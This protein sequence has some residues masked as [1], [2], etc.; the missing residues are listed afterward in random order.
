MEKV[1]SFKIRNIEDVNELFQYHRTLVSVFNEL[2]ESGSFEIIPIKKGTFK[3]VVLD[4][5][6]AEKRKVKKS[7]AK[8]KV[9][10]TPKLRKRRVL[11]NRKLR[12]FEVKGKVIH[13]IDN[14][15]GKTKQVYH[16]HTEAQEK[17]LINR[18]V[19]NDLRFREAGQ[20]I[21]NTKKPQDVPKII[22]IETKNKHI[23]NP[24]SSKT[25]LSILYYDGEITHL[26]VNT[27]ERAIEI[28][29]QRNNFIQGTQQRT[30][31]AATWDNMSIL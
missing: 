19:R 3:K 10:F 23:W 1:I 25:M 16:I 14:K 7:V 20:V 26:N 29:E 15:T 6:K 24:S 2:K 5:I 31:V 17:M 12:K 18:A 4:S 22:P 30:I 27:R 8:S 13:L 11:S 21:I 9:S 28:V